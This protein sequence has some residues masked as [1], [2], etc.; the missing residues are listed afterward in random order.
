MGCGSCSEP[1]QVGTQSVTNTSEPWKPMQPYLQNVAGAA[2]NIF[3]GKPPQYYP[4][5]TVAPFSPQQ[6]MAMNLIT[7]RALQGSPVTDSAQGQNVATTQGGYLGQNPGNPFYGGIMGM[8]PT[9]NPYTALQGSTA[10]GGFLNGNPWL[11]QQFNRAASA[12]SRNFAE[13]VLPGIDSAAVGAGRYGSGLWSNE[14]DKAYDQL[15]RSLEGMGAQMYGQNYQSERDRMMQAASGIQGAFDTSL[16]RGLQA[17]S[18]ADSAFNAERNNMLQSTAMAPML[19][20][21][22]YADFDRLMGVGDQVQNQ[23]QA[24][25]D[26]QFNRW[27]FNQGTPEMMLNNYANVIGNLGSMGSSGS[28]NTPLYGSNPMQMAAAGASLLP[29][30]A[31]GGGCGCG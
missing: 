12:V 25:T 24:R 27:N 20:Q 16:S 7:G 15:G 18:Q 9:V 17:G 10:M 29:M 13:G 11:D 31:S 26:D 2:Q 23:A 5:S 3:T 1:N 28:Q 14:R 22:D 19:A 8:D 4:G 21:A 6:E 30:L